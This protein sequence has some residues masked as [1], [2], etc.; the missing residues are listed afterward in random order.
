MAHGQLGGLSL[1]HAKE[2]SQVL[3]MPDRVPET[4]AVQPCPRRPRCTLPIVP[5]RRGT[6]EGTLG[7]M[8]PEITLLDQGSKATG[9]VRRDEMLPC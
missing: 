4:C 7:M 3:K 5:S 9:L 2:K 6:G 8:L 1:H